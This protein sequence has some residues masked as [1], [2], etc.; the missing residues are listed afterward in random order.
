MEEKELISKLTTLKNIKPRNE[1]VVLA[2][3]QILN[4][5]QVKAKEY[6]FENKVTQRG[7][8]ANI[9]K[10]TFFSR[11]TYALAVLLIAI[12]G[13]Y[14]LS[15]VVLHKQE[16]DRPVDPV[17]LSELRSNVESFKE[18][19]K[20]L[21]D[22]ARF[23]GENVPLAEK[24]V[25]E[26][27][28]VAKEITNTI[29]KEPKLAKEIALEINNNKTLLNV[30]GASEELKEASNDLY[31]ALD[32]ALIPDLEKLPLTDSQRG[33]L[34]VAKGLYERGDYSGAM[35][36][37]L[38]LNIS[39]EENKVKDSQ[40]NKKEEVKEEHQEQPQEEIIDQDQENNKKIPTIELKYRRVIT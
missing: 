35:E 4:T 3:S 25:K 2:K 11:Y 6:V 15:G 22:M 28:E 32:S 29:R 10:T 23:K 40:D 13:I 9:F 31:K 5:P 1:W 7:T 33:S 21:S 37:I 12:I 38:L 39:I 34:N 19:S 36:N 17:V 8:F 20:N 18:K 14:G 24:E 26:V 27:T 16:I 30:Q